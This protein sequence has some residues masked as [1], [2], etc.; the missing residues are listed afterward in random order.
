MSG[1][2]SFQ[3]L[4]CKSK[5]SFALLQP[6]SCQKSQMAGT[7]LV[8]GRRAAVESSPCKLHSS[9]QGKRALFPVL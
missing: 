1:R 2:G 6:P 3:L 7:D 5:D 9:E 8:E 4:L